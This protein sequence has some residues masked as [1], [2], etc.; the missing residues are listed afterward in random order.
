MKNIKLIGIFLLLV[1]VSA[2]GQTKNWNNLNGANYTINYPSEWE[3]NKSGL[4]GTK[5]IIFSP[6]SSKGDNFKENINLIIQD[7]TAHNIDLNQYV[8]ISEKQIKTIITEG[9]IISSTR[10]NKDGKE[11]QKV[12]YT[13]KQGIYDLQFEQYYW[14]ENNNA[15]ILTFTCKAA[16]FSDYKNIGEKIL[17]SFVLNI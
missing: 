15:Y 17:N 13:G 9:K 6:L 2:C 1:T 14:V 11:F 12:I 16:E 8:K 10:L 3:L 5:F 4:M 7:L